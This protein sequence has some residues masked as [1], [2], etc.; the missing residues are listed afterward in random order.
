M[1]IIFVDIDGPLLPQKLHLMQ[2]NRK[3]GVD[4][5][6]L[7]DQ[8]SVRAFNIWAKYGNAKIVFSTNWALS[9]TENQLKDIMAA[10]G[11]EFDYHADTLTPKRFTSARHS[12]ILGWLGEHNDGE[13]VNFIAVDDDQSCSYIEKI[14]D[15]D[16]PE[17]KDLYSNCTGKWIDVDFRDGMSWENYVDGCEALGIDQEIVNRDEFGIKIRTAVEKAEDKRKL[18]VLLG[19]II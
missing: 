3:V 11:L 14:M 13:Q 9:Y 2:E 17:V 7:F 8:F 6:P 16:K 19:C 12:E 15:H 1:N 5:P 18:D 10:N 4:N